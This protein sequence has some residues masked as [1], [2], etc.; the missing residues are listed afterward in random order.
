MDLS[1][2]V[3]YSRDN[4]VRRI[5][6]T[7]IRYFASYWRHLRGKTLRGFIAVYVEF[8]RGSPLFIQIFIAVYTVPVHSASVHFTDWPHPVAFLVFRSKRAGY[9]KGYMKGAIQTIWM[10]KCSRLV[11]GNSRWQTLRQSFYRRL[12]DRYPSWTKNFCS[13]TKSTS[14]LSIRRLVDLTGRWYLNKRPHISN[15][16]CLVCSSEQSILLG[17]RAYP[18]WWT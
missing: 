16:T 15:S 13:L 4:P 12:T 9:Q 5:F 6:G 17:L 7:A 11:G 1:R 2:V 18:N 14:A 10:I 8:F 3:P